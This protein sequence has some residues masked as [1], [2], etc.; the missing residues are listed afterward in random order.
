M[1]EKKYINGYFM[2]YFIAGYF[3]VDNYCEVKYKKSFDLKISMI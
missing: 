3:K 1:A 2:R